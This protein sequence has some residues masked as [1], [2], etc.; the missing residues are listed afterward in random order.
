MVNVCILFIFRICFDAFSEVFLKLYFF[1]TIYVYAYFLLTNVTSAIYE[2]LLEVFFLK[3][4]IQAKQGKL[5]RQSQ[6][7]IKTIIAHK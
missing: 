4:Y 5:N 2:N 1:N 7:Y 6:K 3:T